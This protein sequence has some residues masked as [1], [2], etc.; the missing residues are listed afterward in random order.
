M[1]NE[2]RA[3]LYDHAYVP[4]HRYVGAPEG[5]RARC[6]RAHGRV[7]REVSAVLEEARSFGAT[8]HRLQGVL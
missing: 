1:S 8:L 4:V 6:R 2:D 3:R 7:L 5:F